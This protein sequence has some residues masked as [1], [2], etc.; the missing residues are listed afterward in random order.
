M[1]HDPLGDRPCD[2]KVNR[3]GRQVATGRANGSPS[4]RHSGEASD[5]FEPEPT[6][7]VLRWVLEATIGRELDLDEWLAVASHRRLQ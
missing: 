1:N 4:S 3:D 7:Y 5:I 2:G 6:V